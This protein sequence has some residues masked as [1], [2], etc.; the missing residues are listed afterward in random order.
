[1]TSVGWE[2]L[3]QPEERAVFGEFGILYFPLN[4][5]FYGYIPGKSLMLSR[6]SDMF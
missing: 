5:F 6:D 3:T 2:F 1:M 4:Y